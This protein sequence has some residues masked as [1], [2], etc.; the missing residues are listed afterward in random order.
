MVDPPVLMA[1]ISLGSTRSGDRRSSPS[2]SVRKGVLASSDV[3][4][5]PGRRESG[6]VRGPFAQRDAATYRCGVAVRRARLRARRALADGSLPVDALSGLHS[7]RALRLVSGVDDWERSS[8]SS[9]KPPS[10]ATA[11]AASRHIG[12]SRSRTVCAA[13][14]GCVRRPRR[15]CTPR[16][17]VSAC[18]CRRRWMAMC[19]RVWSISSVMLGGPEYEFAS[20]GVFFSCGDAS[21]PPHAARLRVS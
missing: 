10:S 2:F 14:L 11:L 6:G 16:S 4:G 12:S 15:S 9:V 1:Q 21:P 19:C 13:S 20:V 18:W 7:L 3:C 17:C 5:A 8:S